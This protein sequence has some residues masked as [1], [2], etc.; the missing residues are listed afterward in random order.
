MNI[1][2]EKLLW[3]LHITKFKKIKVF[4]ACNVILGPGFSTFEISDVAGGQKRTFSA[5]TIESSK[6]FIFT[7]FQKLMWFY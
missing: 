7:Y 6:N 3:T 1:R 2:I 5:L 4:A